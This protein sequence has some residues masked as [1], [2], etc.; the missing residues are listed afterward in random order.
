[1][2]DILKTTIIH[3]APCEGSI[4]PYKE[5]EV[6]YEQ[7]TNATVSIPNHNFLII[8]SDFNAHFGKTS[9]N[10]Y[11][12]QELTNYNGEI[13]AHFAEESNLITA[14]TTFRKIQGKYG[15]ICQI[16]MGEISD[17]L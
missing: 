3:Y 5:A 8:I 9:T 15:H 17:R 4:L 10:Q 16:A 12:F 6:H 7:L 14:N 11:T 13:A 2:I 1:M